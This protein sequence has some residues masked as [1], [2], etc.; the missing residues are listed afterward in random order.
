MSTR[1]E[2]YTKGRKG[3]AACVEVYSYSD[4]NKKASVESRSLT[5]NQFRNW[6]DRQ[7]PDLI[8]SSLFEKDGFRYATMRKL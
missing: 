3:I 1:E 2:Y 5:D 6:L 4:T 7:F 8:V